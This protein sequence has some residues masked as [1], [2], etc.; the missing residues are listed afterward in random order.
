MSDRILVVDDEQNIRRSFEIILGGAGFTVVA[1][2]TGE[3]GLKMIEEELPQALFLDINLPGIDGMEVLRTVRR[4]HPQISVIMIS[5]QASIERAVEATR[6]GAFDF[7]E[8]PFSRDRIHLLARNATEATRLKQEVERLRSGD[9]PDE[10]LG[11]SIQVQQLR[12]IIAKVAKTDARVLILGESGTGKELVASALHEN[13]AR[14]GKAYVRVNCA[15]IPEE[16]IEAELFGAAK[17]AYSGAVADRTGRFAAADGG[18]L[19]LDEIGDMSMRAQAKVLRVLQ[20]GEFEPVG[21]T[22]TVSVDVRVIAATH[23]NLSELVGEGRFREDLYHRLGVIPMTVPALRDREGDIALLMNYFLESYG[24]RHELPVP[25]LT[26]AAMKL[27]EAYSWSGNVRELK[28][29]AERLLILNQGIEVGPEDLPLELRGTAAVSDPGKRNPYGHLPLRD[30][31]DAVERDLIQE[32][33]S[34][35]G[36]NVTHTARDL[37]VERTHLHKRIKALGVTDA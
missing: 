21:S 3:L 32:A 20:E 1:A 6:L 5:G 13:S 34:E 22:K 24:S 19:F 12:E 25:Q 4:A 36:G 37:G 27:L 17:G 14:K 9:G 30:A 18:T 28:N 7:V 33:L 26:G 2:E 8:K 16:L 29:V 11:N 15:A 31:R 35:H 10:M 23:H